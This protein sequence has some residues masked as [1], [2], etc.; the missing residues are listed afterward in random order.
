MCENIKHYIRNKNLQK[1]LT[2]NMI[3]DE[4]VINHLQECS[5][6]FS[7]IERGGGVPVTSYAVVWKRVCSMLFL[8]TSHRRRAS[9]GETSPP[10]GLN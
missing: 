8:I 9:S 2:L 1:T 6:L 4:D 5:V 7:V 3:L 10:S